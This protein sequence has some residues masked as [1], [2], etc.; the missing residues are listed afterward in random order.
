VKTP[1]CAFNIERQSFVT[2]GIAVA[3]TMFAR[4]RGLIGKMRLRADE[5]L[6][7]VPSRGI[8]TIGVLFPIDVIYLDAQLRVIDTVEHLG[9]LRIAPMRW[10]SASVLLLPAGSVS[11]SE[12]VVGDRLLIGTPEDLDRYWTEE[13]KKAQPQA[14]HAGEP[15]SGAKM[16]KKAI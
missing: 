7:I 10:N 3:D 1:F 11:A 9:P 6:W 5:A 2:L 16:L 13:G 8:H 15:G 4:L 12:T 14:S